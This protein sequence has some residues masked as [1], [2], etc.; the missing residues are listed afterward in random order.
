M[1]KNCIFCDLISGKRKEHLN[2][3]PFKVLNETKHTLSFLSVEIPKA[4]DG[5][6]IVTSKKH[7]FNLE[8]VHK[9][10]LH[11]LLSPDN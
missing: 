4:E 6:I 7:F 5:H 11:D 8:D 1:R 2:G 3:L 9:F 10:I